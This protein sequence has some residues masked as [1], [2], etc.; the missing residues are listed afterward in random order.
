MAGVAALL[1]SS[2]G[3]SLAS[4]VGGIVSSLA[5]PGAQ[6]RANEKFALYSFG[7]QKQLTRF[8][9]SQQEG[10]Q[11]WTAKQ[12]TS[13][14]LPGS[15]AYMSPGAMNAIPRLNENTG[16]VGFRQSMY[17]PSGPRYTGSQTQQMF[18]AGNT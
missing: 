8:N 15:L 3:G 13:N 18:G 7:L 4:S 17:D 1:G 12:F 6:E 2:I 11:N 5:G 14:G 16:G 10:Y 9:I